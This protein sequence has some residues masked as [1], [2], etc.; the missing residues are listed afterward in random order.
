MNDSKTT[1]LQPKW[2]IFRVPK[3]NINL[4]FTFKQYNFQILR[5]NKDTFK[6]TETICHQHF[7][8]VRKNGPWAERRDL[9]CSQIM[10]EMKSNEKEKYI[11]KSQ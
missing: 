11:G 10:E 9:G 7:C 2:A 8:L 1:A 4:E 5:Q 6:Q 3:E